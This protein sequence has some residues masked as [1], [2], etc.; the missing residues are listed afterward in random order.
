MKMSVS[1]KLESW[2]T[3]GDNSCAVKEAK[4]GKGQ[5]RRHY[6]IVVDGGGVV[7]EVKVIELL[8]KGINKVGFWER[9]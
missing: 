6:A 8:G 2:G 7:F 5:I 3:G 1:G 4:E 9:G